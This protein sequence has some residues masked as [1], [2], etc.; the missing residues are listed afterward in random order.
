MTLQKL[1]P[2]EVEEWFD[3]AFKG[4]P[5]DARAW[6]ERT[7]SPNY[8]RFAAGR[9]RTD[10]E[11]AVEKVK[12]FRTICKKWVAPVTFLVQEENRIS[13]Q[14]KVEMQIGEGPEKKME[15]MF[16]ATRDAQG[17]FENMFELSSDLEE[18]AK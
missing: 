17:R 6:C 16:M 11:R 7:M 5:E 14:M 2:N 10:F 1:T 4:D 13:G 8:L 3:G 15:L 18:G 9:D 12:L